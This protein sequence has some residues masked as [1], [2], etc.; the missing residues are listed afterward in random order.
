MDQELNP[1]NSIWNTYM[2]HVQ[3]DQI[4]VNI[5]IIEEEVEEEEEEEE[6]EDYDW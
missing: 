6:E 4:G 2:K 3:Q 5:V 1:Q